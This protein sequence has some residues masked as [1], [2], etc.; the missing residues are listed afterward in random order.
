VEHTR[1]KNKGTFYWKKSNGMKREKCLK[2]ISKTESD[3]D[4]LKDTQISMVGDLLGKE[5]YMEI[6]M[7][8]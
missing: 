8:E 1:T 2:G 4:T 6:S 7:L 5:G 3:R